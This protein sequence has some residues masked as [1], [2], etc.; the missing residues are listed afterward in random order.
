MQWP[1]N[2]KRH[3]MILDK[4]TILSLYAFAAMGALYGFDLPFGEI[5]RL[6]VIGVGLVWLVVVRDVATTWKSE[7]IQLLYFLV[8]V[9]I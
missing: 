7:N 9:F 3:S 6:L 5:I 8:Y 4:T 1:L 2:L